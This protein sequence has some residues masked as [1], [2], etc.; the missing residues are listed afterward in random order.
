MFS[1][2]F[3]TINE[4][5]NIDNFPYNLVVARSEYLSQQQQQQ[6]QHQQQ[7]QQQQ[8]HRL[9]QQQSH[10]HVHHSMLPPPSPVVPCAV[11]SPVV[12]G[13]ATGSV[14]NIIGRSSAY[15]GT[16]LHQMQQPVLDVFSNGAMGFLN[17]G[18]AN[19]HH[20]GRAINMNIFAGMGLLFTQDD[21][22]MVLYGYVKS[23]SEDQLIG[24]SLSGLRVGELSYGNILSN[25]IKPDFN[26][27][28]QDSCEWYQDNTP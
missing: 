28:N 9:R 6:H 13:T 23:K 14:P 25:R 5:H 26:V 11:P 19:F 4:K 20:G 16:S 24:H 7:Q 10:Q 15:I 17:S 2:L 1:F 8:Q 12:V 21:L 22:D 3:R 18:M 27:I